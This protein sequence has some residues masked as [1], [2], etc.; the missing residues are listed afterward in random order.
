L[1][2]VFLYVT[3]SACVV[4][5]LGLAWRNEMHRRH[6]AEAIAATSGTALQTAQERIAKLDQ[7]DSQLTSRV[8]DLSRELRAASSQASRRGDALRDVRNILRSTATFFGAVEGLDETVGDTVDSETALPKV[9]TRLAARVKALDAY[10]RAT[11]EHNLDRALLRLRLRA[12]VRQLTAI[13]TVIVQ[14]TEGKEALADSV[15]PLGQMKD[16]DR[17]VRAALERAKK[18]LRR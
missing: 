10:V 11:P 4:V 6:A 5:L 13:E 3:A 17:S 18:A 8:A 12:I 15:E 16:L 2:F 7:R 14:L 9:A 1:L